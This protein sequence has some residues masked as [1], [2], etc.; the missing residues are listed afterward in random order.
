P[1]FNPRPAPSS[2][3]LTCGMLSLG[4][5]QL[6]TSG[7]IRNYGRW[8]QKCIHQNFTGGICPGY[9][10]HGPET[11]VDQISPDAQLYIAYRKSLEEISAG[12]TIPCGAPNCQA[13]TSKNPRPANRLCQRSV[14]C[15]SQCCRRRGGC[16]V[17]KVKGVECLSQTFSQSQVWCLF[18]YPTENPPAS[19]SGLDSSTTISVSAP[20]NAPPSQSQHAYARPLD[21]AYGSAWQ[22]AQEDRRKNEERAKLQQR[23]QEQANN[24]V[25]IVLWA[26]ENNA[27]I[28]CNLVTDQPGYLYPQ[29]HEYLMNSLGNPKQI[30]F[31]ATW[32][33]VDWIVQDVGVPIIVNKGSRILI[34]DTSFSKSS[35]LFVDKEIALLLDQSGMPF[36]PNSAPA[37]LQTAPPNNVFEYSA[38]SMG[39]D[40]APLCFPRV[41]R[42]I[43]PLPFPRTRISEMVKGL[44]DTML[45][46]GED[47]LAAAFKRAFP[48]CAY[49]QTSLKTA[50]NL[51]WRA[52]EIGGNKLMEDYIRQG[53]TEKG[54][55]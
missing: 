42:T 4:N 16:K 39:T 28:R 22:Q 15:C 47:Q 12:T 25:Q 34:H 45:L 27:P 48:D 37:L 26:K 18:I 43:R 24:T 38:S 11:S 29:R 5:L 55:W 32:P 17:H 7:E 10:W 52:L 51:L 9:K 19:A 44:K 35:C 53:Q 23:A 31:L 2:Q 33:T 54:L 3:C 14:V 1:N 36:Q 8:F 41:P 21:G 49:G 30:S 6:C 50:R 20:T 13:V 40:S 46:K